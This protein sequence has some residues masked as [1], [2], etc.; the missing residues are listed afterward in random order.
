MRGREEEL[1]YRRG[2]EARS[3]KKTDGG[4]VA[5]LGRVARS[6][7]WSGE[8]AEGAEV[9]NPGHFF[10]AETQGRGET[11]V[12]MGSKTRVAFAAA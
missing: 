12:S 2:A 1:I 11:L 10:D 6:G 3:K 4:D 9:W 5:C 8:E 7:G